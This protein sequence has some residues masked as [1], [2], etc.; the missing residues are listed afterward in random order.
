MARLGTHIII[1]KKPTQYCSWAP[2]GLDGWY[3]SGP[4]T[5][6]TSA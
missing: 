5:I 3:T 6:S 2:H 1:H 4:R